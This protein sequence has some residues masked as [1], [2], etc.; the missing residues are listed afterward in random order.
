MATLPDG[1]RSWFERAGL[2]LGDLKGFSGLQ[3]TSELADR[4][5]QQGVKGLDHRAPYFEQL[6]TDGGCDPG[7][8]SERELGVP[9]DWAWF[10]FAVNDD[11]EELRTRC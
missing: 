5:S 3:R 4:L 7:F 9:A 1:M 11:I 10:E 6:L 2:R 8:L